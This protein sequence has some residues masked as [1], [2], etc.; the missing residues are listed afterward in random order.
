MNDRQA[1]PNDRL[2][3]DRLTNDRLTNDRLANDR[4]TTGKP[5]AKTGKKPGNHRKKNDWEKTG[6]LQKLKQQ[7]NISQMASKRL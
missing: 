2:A 6:E 4:Q 5:P 3:N 7:P 1:S